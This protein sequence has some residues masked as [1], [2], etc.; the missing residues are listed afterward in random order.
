MV[1]SVMPFVF[2]ACTA[3]TQR[4]F[5]K[6]DVAS[7]RTL[8]QEFVSAYNAKDPAKLATLFAGGVAMMPPNAS[9]VR[10]TEGVQEYFASRFGQGA[11]DL[12]VDPKDIS[13]AGPLAYASGDY[14]LKMVPPA[15]GPERR[16]RGKFLWIL[17]DFRGK[18]LLEYLIFSSDFLPG[19]PTNRP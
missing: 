12:V 7:I 18:W 6:A 4:E 15:G 14:S 11:S 13:G 16:D 5:S 8:A 10:G 1:A 9:T 17:R 2:A 3:P 19:P